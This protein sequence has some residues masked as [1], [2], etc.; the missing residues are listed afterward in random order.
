[1]ANNKLFGTMIDPACV[2]CRYGRPAPDKVM[3]FCRKYG[4]VSPYYKCKKYEYDPL[5]RIPV[6]QPKLPAFTEEDFNI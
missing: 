5:K 4:P 2:H 6:R 1:M 3:I